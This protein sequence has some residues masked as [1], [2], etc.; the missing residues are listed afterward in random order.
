MP[1]RALITG[2]TGQ[3]GAYLAELLLAKGYEVHGI[4]R[5]AS[6]FNTARIDH[7]YQDPHDQ[8]RN[9]VLHHGDMTDSCSLIRIVQSVQP[10]GISPAYVAAKGGLDALTYEL[11]VLYGRAG[12]RVLS[13]S[14][15]AVDT[16]LSQDLAD[17]EGRSLTAE[18]RR[19]SED[20]IPLGRWARAEEIARLL[21][22]LASD[23]A[24]YL[25]GVTV[26]A[27]GGWSHNANPYRIKR[28]FN[29]EQFA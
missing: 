6:L 13:V 9:F 8:P 11:A 12:I 2:V 5:R 24:S 29:P 21:V 14:P 28:L 1:K 23:D 10:D 7:L 19:A 25:T 26:V 15:G 20:A 4:K 27:D 17:A 16:A 18:L 3:D 22:L